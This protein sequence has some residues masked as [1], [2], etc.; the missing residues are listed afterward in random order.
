MQG[1]ARLLT[2][3]ALASPNPA[4]MLNGRYCTSSTRLQLPDPAHDRRDGPHPRHGDGAGR[5]DRAI[6][7]VQVTEPRT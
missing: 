1:R 4:H 5:K 6:S 2:R 3:Q 7:A